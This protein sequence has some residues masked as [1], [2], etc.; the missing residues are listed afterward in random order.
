MDIH[1]VWC[2]NQACGQRSH[3]LVAD[4]LVSGRVD[5]ASVIGWA[6]QVNAQGWGHRRIAARLAVPAS[7]VRRWLRLAVRYGIQI[8]GRLLATAAAADPAVRAPPEGPPV[9]VMVAAAHLA[10]GAYGG[11]AASPCRCGVTRWR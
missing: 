8:A 9:G 4:V 11:C 10:A 5:L 3:S 1:R 6:L 2:A 7:T